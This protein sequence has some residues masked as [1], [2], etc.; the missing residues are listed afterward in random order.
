MFKIIKKKNLFLFRQACA[1]E[2]AARLNPNRD[3]FV[4]F[5]SPVGVRLNESLP[6][7]YNKLQV[8]NNVYVR[9]M[10]LWRY[11]F[12]TPIFDWLRTN[13]LFE[14]AYLFEHMSDIVRALTLYRYGGYH[15][16]L[17]IIV[18]R[19][20]DDLGNDFIGDDWATVVNGAVMHLNNYG[21]GREMSQRFF[22]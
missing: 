2:S 1:I 7:F 15:F 16:D 20:I 9:N 17:D 4:I 11:S 13:K 3:I 22:G 14:S 21:I 6:Q 12:D 10:N 5:A 18:Q 8:Y 19:N